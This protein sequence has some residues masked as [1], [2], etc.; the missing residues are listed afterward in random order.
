V[1]GRDGVFEYYEFKDEVTQI[2]Q[3][4]TQKPNGKLRDEVLTPHS[5]AR[6]AQS[7]RCERA[8]GRRI[9]IVRITGTAS[10]PRYF[11]P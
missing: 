6:Y 4:G 2:A 9:V 1:E 10:L 8:S 11:Y 3:F 5:G 7:R